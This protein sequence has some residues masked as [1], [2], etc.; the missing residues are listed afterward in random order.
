MAGFGP[1]RHKSRSVRGL[2]FGA[3]IKYS[4]TLFCGGSSQGAFVAVFSG[5]AHRWE[6]SARSEPAWRAVGSHSCCKGDCARWP[7]ALR[8]R[9]PRASRVPPPPWV[10]APRHGPPPISPSGL[11]YRVHRSRSG[12]GLCCFAG[13]PGAPAPMVRGSAY[14]FGALPHVRATPSG[15]SSLGPSLAPAGPGVLLPVP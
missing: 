15:R 14:G 2:I 13:H 11:H 3:C 5:S 6:L 12:P 1:V 8:A 7:T 10:V 9:R 4:R